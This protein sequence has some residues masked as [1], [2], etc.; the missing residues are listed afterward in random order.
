MCHSLGMDISIILQSD[1]NVPRFDSCSMSSSDAC[2][3]TFDE[4][5]E[6]TYTILQRT[7]ILEK[8]AY[9]IEDLFQ[10]A[11]DI[12]CCFDCCC[13]YWCCCLSVGCCK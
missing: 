3:M 2:L 6:R 8:F 1:L 13:C 11:D 10:A 5:C 12:I 9:F 4:L 7:I